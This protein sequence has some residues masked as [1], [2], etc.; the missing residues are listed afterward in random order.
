VVGQ[1]GGVG[2]QERVQAATVGLGRGVLGERDDRDQE[3]VD[4]RV[5]Q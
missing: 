1:V 5:D 3:V 4:D 2:G